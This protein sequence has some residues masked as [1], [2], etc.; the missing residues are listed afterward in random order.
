MK[1][2]TVI[3]VKVKGCIALLHILLVCICSYNKIISVIQIF[4][5]G[6]L[7]F[8]H[9]IFTWQDV[10]LLDYFLKPEWVCMQR[11]VGNT[12]F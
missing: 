8:A 12:D 6:Y 9:S 4:N 5:F 1:Q 2:V 7:S 3:L 11:S 10:R